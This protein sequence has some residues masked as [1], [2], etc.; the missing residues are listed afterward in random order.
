[1][2][3]MQPILFMALMFG[4]FWFVLIRPQMKRQ[5]EH[6]MLLS[7][8]KPGDEVVTRGGLIAR[9]KNVPEG[10]PVLTVEL[11]NQSTVRIL[12]SYI[13]G[14]HTPVQPSITKTTSKG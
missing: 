14:L 4:I 6:Q 11:Q 12:R 2:Q 1:M 5:K 7:N 3:S 9:V 13:D 8:L 10:Q